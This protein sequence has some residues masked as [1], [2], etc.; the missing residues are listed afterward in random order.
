MIH[1]MLTS[2]PVMLGLTVG[3]YLLAVWIRTRSKLMLLNPMLISVPIIIAFLLIFNIPAQHYIQSNSMISFMLGPSVVALGLT[4]YEQRM[5]IKEYLLPILSAVVVGSI[6]GVVSVYLLCRWFQLN[7]VFMLALEPKSVTVP[8][9]MEVAKGIGGN[10]AITHIGSIVTS[11]DERTQGDVGTTTRKGI[12]SC[13]TR[14][15]IPEILANNRKTSLG[16]EHLWRKFVHHLGIRHHGLLGIDLSHTHGPAGGK[17]EQLVVLRLVATVT[18]TLNATT[19]TY[20]EDITTLDGGMIQ[21]TSHSTQGLLARSVSGL[22]HGV[23]LNHHTGCGQELV[24]HVL[25]HQTYHAVVVENGIALWFLHRLLER[26]TGATLIAILVDKIAT[27]NEV[28]LIKVILQPYVLHVHLAQGIAHVNLTLPLAIGKIDTNTHVRDAYPT[29]QLV[30]LML[31][32][33]IGRIK[34]NTA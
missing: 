4:M 22:L 31:R 18:G 23:S 11:L 28:L 16:I 14:N 34:K 13:I 12:Q 3:V 2:T 1:E 8:I 27:T 17:R 21:Q 26:R 6:V 24:V 32:I 33:D 19:D 9:A 30:L 10:T 29:V 7:D 25:I 20:M 5:T 15:T